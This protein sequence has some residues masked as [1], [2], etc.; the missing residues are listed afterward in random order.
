[1]SPAAATH[2]KVTHDDV[3]RLVEPPATPAPPPAAETDTTVVK[4]TGMRKMVADAV[5]RSAQTAP[6]VTLTL[7]VDMSEA[8]RFRQQVLPAIEKTHGV[9]VSFTDIIAKAAARAL[10]DH[11]YLNSTLP[12]AR[13]PCTSASTWAS[14][15]PWARTA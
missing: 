11:P 3:R 15:S 13:S 9:R 5:A 2:G 6:H 14:P 7:A 8:T 4:L 12:A 1:M 10:Q